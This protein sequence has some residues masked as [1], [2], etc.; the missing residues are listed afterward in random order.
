MRNQGRSI[1]FCVNPNTNVGALVGLL[2]GGLLLGG[3]RVRADDYR[4]ATPPGSH[5]G[6]I[7]HTARHATSAWKTAAARFELEA[8]RH[9]VARGPGYLYNIESTRTTLVLKGHRGKGDTPEAATVVTLSFLGA[10]AR[11]AIAGEHKAPGR[12]NYFIG[13]DPHSWRTNVPGYERVRVR[14]IYPGIDLV[15]YGNGQQLEYDFIVAPQRDP[16]IIGLR[17]DGV[18]HVTVDRSGDLVLE[19]PQGTLHHVAPRI[20]QR[21]GNERVSVAGRYVLHGQEVGFDVGAY[22]HARAR[23]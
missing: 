9:F 17:F 7:P 4:S 18:D 12:S 11:A 6:L 8:N 23:D 5:D 19:T 13:T 22:D 10:N 14:S 21:R 20:Y 3:V 15:H 1:V 2:I 16:R